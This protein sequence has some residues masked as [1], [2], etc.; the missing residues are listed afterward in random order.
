MTVELLQK[1]KTALQTRSPGVYNIVNSAVATVF[2]R[3]PNL[4]SFPT[5]VKNTSTAVKMQDVGIGSIIDFRKVDG[6][7]KIGIF[8]YNFENS[9]LVL[10]MYM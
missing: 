5:T 1:L 3:E 9:A 10:N 7:L 8:L 2:R 4:C 6:L